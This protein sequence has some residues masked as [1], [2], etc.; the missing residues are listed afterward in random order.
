MWNQHDCQHH[1]RNHHH[2]RWHHRSR[3]PSL[4]SLHLCQ[5]DVI[6]IITIITNIIMP[7]CPRIW[8]GGHISIGS[9]STWWRQRPRSQ[10]II[11]RLTIRM[12]SLGGLY[13]IIYLGLF[14]S[15]NFIRSVFRDALYRLLPEG[16]PQNRFLWRPPSGSKSLRCFVLFNF[17]VT[18]CLVTRMIDQRCIC[19]YHFIKVAVQ[20][21]HIWRAI[22]MLLEYKYDWIIS[23]LLIFRVIFQLILSKST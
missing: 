5:G 20:S 3:H 9:S 11:Q 18:W 17:T 13:F 15:Y 14:F 19:W 23:L 2:N 1:N 10:P 7:G 21:S 6:R 4:Q 22:D 8:A 16:R 12:S